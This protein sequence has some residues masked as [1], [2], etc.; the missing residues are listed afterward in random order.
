MNTHGWF[1][2]AEPQGGT[3]VIYRLFD[4]SHSDRCGAVSLVILLRITLMIGD[5]E[6]LFMCLLA[7][8]IT[9]LDKYLFRFA[10]ITGQFSL[11]TLLLNVKDSEGFWPNLR[12]DYRDFNT[13]LCTLFLKL[14]CNLFQYLHFFFFCSH[15][16]HRGLNIKLDTPFTYSFHNQ[17]FVSFLVQHRSFS[18]HKTSSQDHPL[19]FSIFATL[20]NMLSFILSN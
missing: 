3:S 9:S 11:S 1:I 2:T 16:L 14:V 17:N 4:D 12:K 8:C 7:I 5:V 13:L 18:L 10:V 20:P 6:H 19:Q 15:K